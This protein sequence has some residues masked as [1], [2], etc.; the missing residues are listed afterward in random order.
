MAA[1][2]ELAQGGR[3]PR[4]KLQQPGVIEVVVIANDCSVAIKDDRALALRLRCGQWMRHSQASYRKRRSASKPQPWLH[5]NL[6][7]L[8]RI[9]MNCGI[10][11]EYVPGSPGDL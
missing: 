1:L 9:G 5:F 11:P 4:E 6:E 7:T 3:G 8:R 10:Q 2:P